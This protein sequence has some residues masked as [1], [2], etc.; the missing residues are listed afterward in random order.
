MKTL[1]M[2]LFT[3]LMIVTFGCSS[4]TDSDSTDNNGQSEILG[5]YAGVLI[6]SSG[7]Y[8][9][10]VG[11]TGSSATINF[12]GEQYNLSNATPIASDIVYSE[13]TFTNGTISATLIAD[14][15]AMPT[16]SFDIPGHV[17]Q[18]TIDHITAGTLTLYEGS[19][20]STN[21][22]EFY[23]ATYNLTLRDGGDCDGCKSFN[24][25][26]KV[27]GSSN[28][29]QIGNTDYIFGKYEISG[30]II[31]FRHLNDEVIVS[32]TINGNTISH[33][34]QGFEFLFT[35]KKQLRI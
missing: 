1:K 26:E 6:G 2:S 13:L 9:I 5:T 30:N 8:S 23:N 3:V 17:I 29:N 33:S 14:V 10:E 22:G 35:E 15:D 19:S 11:E 12:D 16:I 7:Y 28:S 27:T 25:L 32:G 24:I 20:S 21:G 31:T 4:D 34:E 18:S